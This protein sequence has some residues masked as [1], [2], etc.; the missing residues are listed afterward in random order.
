MNTT[1]DNHIDYNDLIIKYLM[2]SI[3]RE[4]LEILLDWIESD[5][6]HK[7]H[8]QALQDAWIISGFAQEKKAFVSELAWDDLTNT[9]HQEPLN[10]IKIIRKPHLS[11]YFKLA[12]SWLV[13]FALGLSVMYFIK[14]KADLTSSDPVEI[15]V[16]LGAKSQVVLPD[17][18]KIWI[19]AGTRL[20]YNQNYGRKTRTLDLSGEAY[21]DVA[22][23][24]LHPFI[25]KTQGIMIR[26]LGTRFNVK[27]YPEENIVR[28][29]LE[30]GKINIRFPA[31]SGKIKN[32]VLLPDEN[33]V[34]LKSEDIALKSTAENAPGIKGKIKENIIPEPLKGSE[35]KLFKN[36]N[37][38]LYTSWKENRWIIKSEPLDL[39][40]PML[41]RKFNI[42][43]IFKDSELKNFNFT[44]TIQNE[45]V[46]QIM[47]AMSM[48]SP[49]D[50][51][52]IK[53]TVII[54]SNPVKQLRFKQFIKIS[55]P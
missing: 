37:T 49:L 12:A 40:A 5:K 53:D 46:E 48:T 3:S 7:I 9:L 47:H 50:F 22:K 35:V 8:F 23:D 54:S 17:G 42:K 4:D 52:I 38:E 28:A 33:M 10:K 39:L 16:P 19:N 14:G 25:V 45:S 55:K 51:W 11:Q 1:E 15:T 36:I 27:S 26:A 41:E 30:E 2:E 31:S 18:S 32:L 43:I 13:F 44:G 29:T 34:Y 24:K 21:F 20:T 6:Q